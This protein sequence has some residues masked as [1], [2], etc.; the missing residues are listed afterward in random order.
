MNDQEIL[1]LG[2][3]VLTTEGAGIESLKN[4]LD[5]NFIIACKNIL[6]T[7]GKVITIGL[8]KSGHIARKISATFA[9]TGT[10]S[11]F[12]HGAEAIHGDLGMIAKND[13]VILISNSGETSELLLIQQS[14]KN[15]PVQ[16]VAIT[17]NSKSRLAAQ[18]D[19]VLLLSKY[20]EAC[21]L[22]LAPTTSTTLTLALGDALAVCLLQLRK[23]TKEGFA[24]THPA[25]SLGKKL[26]TKVSDLMHKGADIPLVPIDATLATSLIEITKK[27]LGCA[28]V[29]TVDKVVGIY[30]DGDLR[31][32]LGTAITSNYNLEVKISDLIS[33]VF[34]SCNQE[35]LAIEAFHI[36]KN[37]KINVLVVLDSSGALA[38]I[39]HA[40]DLIQHKLSHD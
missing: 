39:L 22:N 19:T 16:S 38:G 2:K 34:I 29:G 10:P 32:T 5:N 27:R 23:L 31:R 12:I 36:M 1:E 25:G 21:P 6:A 35:I 4:S 11:F 15:I 3:S 24:R 14:L 30:T 40:H 13:L 20:Q 28:L 26:T 37:N 9:S 18:S 17:S 7:K 33:D 8:G